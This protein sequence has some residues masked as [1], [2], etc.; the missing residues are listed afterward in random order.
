M[1]LAPAVRFCLRPYSSFPFSDG[2]A[3]PCPCLVPAVF[4]ASYCGCFV[5]VSVLPPLLVSHLSLGSLRPALLFCASAAFSP[6]A[7]DLAAAR[8][9]FARVP[10]GLAFT[11]PSHIR[12]Q[13][14]AFAALILQSNGVVAFRLLWFLTLC[15]L[16]PLLIRALSPRSSRLARQPKL[17]SPALR[18]RSPH[19]LSPIAPSQAPDLSLWSSHIRPQLPRVPPPRRSRDALVAHSACVSP[20]LRLV[21]T[22]SAHL[23]LAM[24]LLLLYRLSSASHCSLHPPPRWGCYLSLLPV[25]VVASLPIP[26]LLVPATRLF[27]APPSPFPLRLCRPGSA[28]SAR[29]CCFVLRRSSRRS[30]TLL[31]IVLSSSDDASWK[32]ALLALSLLL[33]PFHS[34]LAL[35]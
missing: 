18:F 34:S 13:V 6:F 14:W 3:F 12:I 28:F 1:H 16:F 5:F 7:S 26:R 21:R 22:L 2:Q 19:A 15:P 10:C 32:V 25:C 11:P 4:A 35:T 8:R 24:R 17:L 20:P 33:S 29:W 9:Q 27:P 23:P 30:H 31:P